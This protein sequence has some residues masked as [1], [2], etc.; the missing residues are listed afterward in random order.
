MQTTVRCDVVNLPVRLFV[1]VEVRFY[2]NCSTAICLYGYQQ[3]LI[4]F[5]AHP[6]KTNTQTITAES[7]NIHR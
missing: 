1:V 2:N 5:L 6:E 7:H 4:L 3:I